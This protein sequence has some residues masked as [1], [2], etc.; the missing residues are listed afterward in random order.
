MSLGG[1]L[2]EQ[3]FERRIVVVTGRLDDD[4]ARALSRRARGARL[5]P[6]RR[7]HGRQVA[8]RKR[9]VTS[10]ARGEVVNR[11]LLCQPLERDTAG[12][13]DL[14]AVPFGVGPPASAVRRPMSTTAT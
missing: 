1:S 7:D 3:L 2:Q 10:G 13:G 12:A 6:Y 5:R 8:P 14:E 9:L 4:A 11:V